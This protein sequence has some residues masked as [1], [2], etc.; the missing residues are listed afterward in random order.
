MLRYSI[1][2]SVTGSGMFVSVAVLECG[3]DLVRED[4]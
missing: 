2:V 1:F 3:C 4:V